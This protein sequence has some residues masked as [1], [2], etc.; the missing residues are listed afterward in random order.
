M[1]NITRYA[2]I[3]SKVKA[4]QKKLL[5]IEQYKKI[6]Q[7]ENYKE[8][9]SFISNETYYGEILKKYNLREIHRGQLEYILMKEYISNFEKIICFFYGEYKSF[10]KAM[11]MK[12]QLQDLRL[13]LRDK[14]TGRQNNYLNLLITYDSSLNDLNFE[15]IIST[16]N[17]NE[18]INA[19]EGSNY[20][21]YLKGISSHIEEETL[22][23][24]E[25]TLDFM[26]YSYL[27]KSISKLNKKDKDIMNEIVGIY[28]DL[29]NVYFIY[30]A[31]KYYDLTSEEMLNY[32][33]PDGFKIKI[34]KLKKLCYSKD[35][36]EFQEILLTT[37]Y[38]KFVK[39]YERDDYLMER[40]ILMY[41]SKI[42]LKNKK[43]HENNISTVVA[44]LELALI[45]I[46]NIISLIE[47]KRYGIN[48]E[49]LYKYL[50]LTID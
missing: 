36:N 44:Y 48:N 42:H 40:D 11:F 39:Y 2:A 21:K 32:A 20:Y 7:C 5:T 46:R 17:I 6:I 34:D 49:D 12:F 4:M 10:F 37:K 35:K 31:K 16:N 41:I 18:A 27:Q 33:I 26:Y 13:I 23:R 45:E 25:V 22:F 3:N 29:F 50:S 8:V 14:Y 15:K 47:I 28:I 38:G 1:G 30:R 24:I 9:L 43:E 19:L